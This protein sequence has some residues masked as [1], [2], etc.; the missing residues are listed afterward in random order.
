MDPSSIW[1]LAPPFRVQVSTEQLTVPQLSPFKKMS[2]CFHFIQASFPVLLIP[3]FTMKLHVLALLPLLA[4]ASI[5]PER[6][7]RL[8][9][10]ANNSNCQSIRHFSPH[11]EYP[12]V[13]TGTIESHVDSFKVNQ[14][15]V[16]NYKSS[17]LDV[18]VNMN[19]GSAEKGV[20]ITNIRQSPSCTLSLQLSALK[21]N[22]TVLLADHYIITRMI[23][24]VTDWAR[25]V[26]YLGSRNRERILRKSVIK[27][28]NDHYTTHSSLL[29][30][31]QLE[32]SWTKFATHRVPGFVVS[33]GTE[34]SMVLYPELNIFKPPT[35]K[36]NQTVAEQYNSWFADMGMESYFWANFF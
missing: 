16:M 30:K 12:E 36:L 9:S 32:L 8:E 1:S 17:Y 34:V 14:L 33:F 5:E 18:V 11:N 26:V 6:M 13:S 19:P 20:Y 2:F 4:L 27:T 10:A 7:A 35:P 29:D 23:K 25:M 3:S 22:D 24:Y 15:D 28:G 31:T 21:L